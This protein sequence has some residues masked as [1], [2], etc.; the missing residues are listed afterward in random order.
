MSSLPELRKAGANLKH[1]VSPFLKFMQLL[2]YLVS[3]APKRSK[4]HN[5]KIK[6]NGSISHKTIDIPSF[7]D[8]KN[9]F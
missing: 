1:A 7:W 2:N 3:E 4:R 6:V 9:I 5:H 8:Q